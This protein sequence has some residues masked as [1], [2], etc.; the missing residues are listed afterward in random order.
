M[1]AGEDQHGTCP[2]RAQREAW[3]EV[4]AREAGAVIKHEKAGILIRKQD[5]NPRVWK[6][7]SDGKTRDRGA[8]QN[9]LAERYWSKAE[10]AERAKQKTA[11]LTRQGQVDEINRPTL[12]SKPREVE[13]ELETET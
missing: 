3:E 5:Q 8:E 10:V 2:E 7:R 13:I 6:S 4:L 11:E 9:G 12:A 1:D